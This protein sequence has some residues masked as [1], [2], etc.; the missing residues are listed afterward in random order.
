V[1]APLLRQFDV[2]LELTCPQQ[3]VHV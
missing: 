2:T 3:H 1:S